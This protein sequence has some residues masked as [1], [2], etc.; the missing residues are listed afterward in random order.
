MNTISGMNSQ[1]EAFAHF[2]KLCCEFDESGRIFWKRP[3]FNCRERGFVI[4]VEP[5]G[6]A[7]GDKAAHHFAWFEHR[8]S[9]NLC[10]VSWKGPRS[11]KSGDF[12]TC[13]DIPDKAYPTKWDVT[14]SFGYGSF[15]EAAS[16]LHNQIDAVCP[17]VRTA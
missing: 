4:T 8:N 13:D 11:G 7:G 6:K 3:Y 14:K 12:F 16:W 10:C 1:A 9:D 17:A 5:H 2:L 15:G